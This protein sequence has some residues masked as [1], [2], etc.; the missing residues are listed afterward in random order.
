MNC[1]CIDVG[2]VDLYFDDI[3]GTVVD[4]QSESDLL[5]AMAA[6]CEHAAAGC[7][8]AQERDF[9]SGAAARYRELAKWLEENSP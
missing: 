2:S 8:D 5:C 9:V 6:K 1:I 3:A 4:N 7:K